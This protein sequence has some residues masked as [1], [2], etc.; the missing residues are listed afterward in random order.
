MNKKME[1]DLNRFIQGDE[2]L[3]HIISFTI[4]QKGLIFVQDKE[5]G[6]IIPPSWFRDI[7]KKMCEFGCLRLNIELDYM[8]NICEW[9]YQVRERQD[10]KK[11]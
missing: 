6:I 8:N 9:D 1:K 5:R 11:E 3:P 2:T 7:V 10:I 4:N